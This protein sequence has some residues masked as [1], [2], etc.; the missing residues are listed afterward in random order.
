MKN[1]SLKTIVGVIAFSL[2]VVLV[3]FWVNS[4]YQ[5]SRISNVFAVADETEVYDVY[6]VVLNELFAKD[7]TKLLVISDKTSD[8]SSIKLKRQFNIFAEY[9]FIDEE[10]YDDKIL[11]D[12]A[13]S[14]QKS[15]KPGIS[16]FFK[17]HQ[18]AL[19]IV[20]ISDVEFNEDK[21]LAEVYVEL[22]HC[23]TCGFGKNVLLEKSKGSWEIKKITSSWIS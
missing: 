3:A 5:L 15:N 17:E 20:K 1:I 9:V 14:A 7:G 18:K 22:T 11:T 19:G 6:S 12:E 2:G 4:S 13:N 23:P 10:K 8:K 16:D 21:T